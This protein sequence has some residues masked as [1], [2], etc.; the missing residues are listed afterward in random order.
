MIKDRLPKLDVL[1]TMGTPEY[2]GLGFIQLKIDTKYRMHFYHDDLIPIVPDEELHDHRYNFTS[3]ILN[4][5]FTQEIYDFQET[6]DGTHQLKE[7]DCQNPDNKMEGSVLG[8]PRLL[9]MST[10]TKG[11]SYWINRDLFHRVK[12]SGNTITILERERVE[13]N[14]ARVISPLG[15]H[16]ICPFSAPL[17]PERC[18][19]LIEDMIKDIE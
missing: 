15:N 17:G 4:G 9:N 13:K 1:K 7:V 10:Y 5:T 16:S 11:S 14:F 12:S 19:E 3:H 6:E 2:F 8:T 18:W